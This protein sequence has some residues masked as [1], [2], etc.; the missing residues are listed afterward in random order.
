MSNLRRGAR[1]DANEPEI[2]D[3]LIAAGASVT[4]INGHGVPDLLVGFRAGTFLL[5]VKLPLGPRGGLSDRDLNEDQRE[6]WK[7]W[8]GAAPVVVRSVDE[9][10]RAIG[11]LEPVSHREELDV[12]PSQ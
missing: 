4:R 8:T 7:T 10:L 6:W 12:P 5:E 3:A 2:F 9:A 11:A 1:R